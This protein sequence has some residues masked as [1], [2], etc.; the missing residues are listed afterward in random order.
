MRLLEPGPD[1]PLCPRLVQYRHQ[2][3]GEHPDW[4]NA[5]VPAFGP[6]AAELLIVG[7][8]PGRAGAN[9]T[10]RPF[11]GDA[12]GAV[13]YAALAKSGLAQ[14]RYEPGRNDDLQMINCRITNAV[15]CAP[16]ANRP[17]AEEVRNCNRFLQSEVA[18]MRRLKIILA[19]GH[20]AHTSVC[21]SLALGQSA[22]PFSHGASH[23]LDH[24]LLVDS[25]HCSR[26]N[27]ATGRLSVQAFERLLAQVKRQLSP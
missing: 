20:I 10:G 8:A 9:R 26:Q 2:L 5:P 24:K 6:L 27:M 4:F 22:L 14:G 12:A 18:A 1:C 3:R 15:R 25:Y 16:R 21:R 11:T 7:L 17:V 19:L 23:V 13:L